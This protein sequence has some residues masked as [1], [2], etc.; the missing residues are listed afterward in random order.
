M[1]VSSSVFGK[2]IKPEKRGKVQIKSEELAIITQQ[3]KRHRNL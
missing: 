2:T 1:I 3:K